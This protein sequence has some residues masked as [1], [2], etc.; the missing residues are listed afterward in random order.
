MWD[1]EEGNFF[2][3]IKEGEYL[4]TRFP[5]SSTYP[6][7]W[8]ITT[9]EQ[10][11]QLATYFSDALIHIGPPVNRHQLTTPYGGFYALASLY[12]HENAALAE[13]FIRKHWGKM[14]YEA[15]DL[16]WE[17]FNR[18]SHSTMSHAWSSSP[19]Y[20]LSSQV[21]GV[22]LGFP[23]TVSPDTIYIQPQGE[24]IQWAK[25]TVPHPLGDV[26]VNWKVEGNQLYLDYK[27][28]PGIPVIV[29][30]RGRLSRLHLVLQSAL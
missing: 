4:S 8:G 16:S 1:P 18:N 29:K 9:P 15:N 10:E 21:L 13:R 25:G 27:A 24:T 17:D 22:D 26:E 6:S 20:Y 5:S 12:R 2:D 11:R 3:G 14:V 28:P 19:T 7:L 23:D 30:P